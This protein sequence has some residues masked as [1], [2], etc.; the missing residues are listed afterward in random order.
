MYTNDLDDG[1]NRN[2]SMCADD[3]EPNGS[4]CEAVRRMQG[5]FV[6]Q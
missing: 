6:G 4:M 5:G 3:T 1:I 2:I